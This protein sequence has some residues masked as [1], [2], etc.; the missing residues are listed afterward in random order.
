M[1]GD[2]KPALGGGL[3]DRKVARLAVGPVGAP[4]EK[5]LDEAF[6]LGHAPDLGR[7][8]L[9]VLGRAEDRR[10]EARLL[11]E[12]PLAEPLVVG[13]GELGRAVGARHERDEHRVVPVQDPDLGAARIEELAAHHVHVG[14]RRVSVLL[15]VGPEPGRRVHP[16]VAGYPERRALAAEPLAL[17]RIDIAEEFLDVPDLRVD[18]AVDHEEDDSPPNM[19]FSSDDWL[20]WL[21]DFLKRRGLP[22]MAVAVTTARASSSSP[23]TAGGPSCASG[24]STRTRSSSSARSAR[25]SRRL[26][27]LVE[28]LDAARA[29]DRLPAVVRGALGVRPD[30]RSSICSCT[31]PGSSAERR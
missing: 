27:S 22:G 28:L 13:A 6:V 12:P 9:R 11:G 16:G 25:R 10:A 29:G 19:P 21:G 17:G 24:R 26:C 5:H 20:A 1:D 14:R 7:G 8:R 15:D 2:G 30:S 18:V 4:A 3:E 31:R 23:A